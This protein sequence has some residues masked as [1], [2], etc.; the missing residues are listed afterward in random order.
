MLNLGKS[1]EKGL[2]I[3]QNAKKSKKIGYFIFNK[4]IESRKVGEYRDRSGRFEPLIGLK[5]L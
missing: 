5:F 2:K 4:H 3:C 1:P